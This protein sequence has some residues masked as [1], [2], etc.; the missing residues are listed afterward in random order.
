LL[1]EAIVCKFLQHLLDGAQSHALVRGN[2]RIGK[3]GVA[4]Q[5]FEDR[6]FFHA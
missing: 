4:E 5:E 2:L 3:L 1:N 6:D